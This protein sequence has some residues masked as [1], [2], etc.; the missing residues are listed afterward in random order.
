M[1]EN[2]VYEGVE[3]TLK[4]IRNRGKKIILASS[5]PM[6]FCEKILQ[7]FKLDKYFDFLVSKL[8]LLPFCNGF[9]LNYFHL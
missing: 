4:E 5:K 2:E 3:E 1:L 6:V 9:H 7:H 8:L